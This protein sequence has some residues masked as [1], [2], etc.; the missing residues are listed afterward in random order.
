MA[1]LTHGNE[2]QK[3]GGRLPRP[4][5]QVARAR[6][7]QRRRRLRGREVGRQV[8]RPRRP[9]QCY[10]PAKVKW[11]GTWTSK[12]LFEAGIGMNNKSCPSRDWQAGSRRQITIPQGRRRDRR[13]PGRTRQLSTIPET[14]SAP[15]RSP[16]ISYATGISARPQGRVRALA[17]LEQDSAVVREPE[18]EL[19]RALLERDPELGRDLQHAEHPAEQPEPRRRPLSSGH[20]HAQAADADARHPVRV[21]QRVVPQEGIAYQRRQLL[22]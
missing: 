20:V 11:T 8:R 3:Q 10:W 7:G 4:C 17:R 6:A 13:R 16:E 1:R 18:R 9:K 5:Q 12:L 21:S 2:R 22:D 19:R 14:R 15:P